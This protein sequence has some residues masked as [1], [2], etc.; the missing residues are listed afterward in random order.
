V[1]AIAMRVNYIRRLIERQPQ[2]ALEE[3]WKVEDLARRTTKEI[4]HMLFTLR[5]LVLETQGLLPAL[6]QLAEK[7]K[8]T[9]DLTVTIE[10]Q[11]DVESFLDI[12]GQGVLFYIIE[13]AVN[14][15]RKHAQSDEIWVRLYRHEGMIATEIEDHGVGF[16]VEAVD[17]SYDRR[18]SLGMINMRERA[19]IIEGT[20]RIESAKG[21]GTKITVLIPAHPAGSSGGNGEST[22]PTE[23]L[24]LQSNRAAAQQATPAASELS[25]APQA[26]VQSQTEPPASISKPSRPKPLTRLQPEKPL[27]GPSPSGTDQPSDGQ[28]APP[29]SER[30]SKLVRPSSLPRPHS[31]KPSASEASLAAPEDSQP[32]RPRAKRSKADKPLPAPPESSPPKE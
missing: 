30:P 9:Y 31:V 14:N 19:E 3:L 18:G 10:G 15:A 8:D 32:A 7:M 28:G 4:R 1:A 2:Q 11:P 16:D 26:S 24:Q 25:P 20:L 22:Q 6:Q 23:P 21:Q 13:E 17:A 27:T 29:S 12:N 5:P